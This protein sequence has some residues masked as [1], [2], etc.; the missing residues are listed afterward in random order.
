MLDS[1]HP[2]DLDVVKLRDGSVIHFKQVVSLRYDY[3]RG[4]RTLRIL[5]SH[6]IRTIHD[7]LIIGID[8]FEVFL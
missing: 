4:T 3:Y 8:D 2:V 7:C 5:A 6:Q 1:G